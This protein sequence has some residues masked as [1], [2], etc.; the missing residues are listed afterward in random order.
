MKK[1]RRRFQKQPH[2]L[3]IVTP[4]KNCR[5]LSLLENNTFVV[6]RNNVRNSERKNIFFLPEKRKH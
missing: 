2:N 4:P 5:F 6:V 3:Y 1:K